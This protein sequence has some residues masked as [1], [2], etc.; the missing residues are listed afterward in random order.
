MEH[1]GI[2]FHT[3]QLIWR[4]CQV[5][6]VTLGLVMKRAILSRLL[7]TRIVFLCYS[8]LMNNIQCCTSIVIVDCK[9]KNV[10]RHTASTFKKCVSSCGWYMATV[11]AMETFPQLQSA[12]TGMNVIYM[13]AYSKQNKKKYQREWKMSHT[14]FNCLGNKIGWLISQAQIRW[15]KLFAKCECYKMVVSLGKNIIYEIQKN[16]DDNNNWIQTMRPK[17]IP[18]HQFRVCFKVPGASGCNTSSQYVKYLASK[19]I[20]EHFSMNTLQ[21]QWSS[22]RATAAVKSLTTL[23]LMSADSSHSACPSA[24]MVSVW[25]I[26]S[27][28]PSENI[29]VWISYKIN[30]AHLEPWQ[31]W[32]VRPPWF[33]CQKIYRPVHVQVRQK[34]QCQKSC[35][36]SPLQ[37][38]QYEYP[39]KTMGPTLSHGSSEKFDRA[40]FDKEILVI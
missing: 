23:I 6:Q 19:V 7:K 21:K 24:A 16:S 40:A 32:K 28:K 12:N 38:F 39:V 2:A 1:P 35:P 31:Q 27:Q 5:Y 4:W 9:C 8:A 15:G 22:P 20:C 11:R 26:L 30:E 37:I 3:F 25:N 17:L 33:W 29:S 14:I 36:E 13:R 10:A 34:S 18:S